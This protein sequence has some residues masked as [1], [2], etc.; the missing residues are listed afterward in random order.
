MSA[1]SIIAELGLTCPHGG[2]FY[3]CQGAET[4][5]LGC[6]TMD[7]CASGK[8]YCPQ[9][10]LRYSS[11]S[12][13]NYISIPPEN[14]DSP[15]NSSSWYTCSNADPPFMGCCAS[16][17]CNAGCSNDD[18]LAARVD[19]DP[20]NA[21][22]FLTATATTTSGSTAIS[23]AGSAA[24]SSASSDNGSTSLS[25]GA[26]V[27][28]AIG[29]SFTALIAAVVLF[30]C[31]KRR[32]KAKKTDLIASGQPS[33]YGTPGAY[34]PSPYQDSFGS[35]GL[36]PGMSPMPPYSAP[37]Y[38]NEKIHGIAD[39]PGQPLY[40][41]PASSS[42][43]WMSAYGPSAHASVS[44]EGSQ[45]WIFQPQQQHLHTLSEMGNTEVLRPV[46]ELPGSG[47]QEPSF[48]TY[49]PGYERVA[50][51]ADDS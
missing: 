21:S 30:L 49:R 43:S 27:G 2:S 5:F 41:R 24:T 7:P 19:D 35:P 38:G 15:Y 20:S 25:T 40:Q 26:I 22:V 23:S 50:T 37:Q 51:N 16:N 32:E 10:S 4:Q 36:S 42:P 8:G 13:D 28:I 3:I 34:L 17:P 1:V 39:L 48:Q 44:S 31:Y 18:L 33:P 29:S 11:Y 9:D 14:C 6:C 47:P 12:K 46:S 45:N